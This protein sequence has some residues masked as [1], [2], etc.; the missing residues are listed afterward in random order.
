M[1]GGSAQILA[2][3][4]MIADELGEHRLRAQDYLTT[5]AVGLGMTAWQPERGL[6]VG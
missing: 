3:R 1:T 2:L 5:V 4:R 6:P